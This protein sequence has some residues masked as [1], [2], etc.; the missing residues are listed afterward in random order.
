MDRIER[1][2]DGWHWLTGSSQD[3]GGQPDRPDR[4]LRRGDR[5]VRVGQ[6]VIIER[7]RQ[8]RR[9]SARLASTPMI[10]L[11][12]ARFHVPHSGSGFPVPSSPRSTALVSR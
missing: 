4:A 2:D 7:A 1:F 9:S 12:Y 11:E 5:L 10:S 8:R 6:S 3:R